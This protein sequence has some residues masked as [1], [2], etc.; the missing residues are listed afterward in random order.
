MAFQLLIQSRIVYG[1]PNSSVG[2]VFIDTDEGI[3]INI[4]TFDHK[5][6]DP[7]TGRFQNNMYKITKKNNDYP[8]PKLKENSTEPISS[9]PDELKILKAELRKILINKE[10]F[11]NMKNGELKRFLVNSFLD[12][13]LG[14]K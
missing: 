6:A 1:N 11:D 8:E 12:R 3:Q 9:E 4:R 2:I 14:T 5:F 13:Q 7:N 10:Y